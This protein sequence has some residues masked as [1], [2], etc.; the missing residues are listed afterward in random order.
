MTEDEKARVNPAYALAQ[1][2]KALS[3]KS[4]QSSKKMEEWMQVLMGLLSGNL[5]IGSRTPI[6]DMPPWV[7][8][9]VIHGGFASG[10][11]AASGNWKPHEIE[12]LQ[13][14]RSSAGLSKDDLDLVLKAK[15]RSSLNMFY[16]SDNGSAELREMLE[17]GCYRIRIAEEGALLIANWL[18]RENQNEQAEK[19]IEL[20][21]PFFSKLR[22]YPEPHQLALRR[23]SAGVYLHTVADV[24]RSLRAKRPQ[25]AV[26]CMK[27]S[28][29]IWAPLYDKCV[30]LFLETIDGEPPRFKKD[31]QGSLIKGENMQPL[32]SGGWP[33]KHFR[34]GWK[35]R[36]RELLHEYENAR[37]EHNLSNKP[38][39]PK[40]NFARLREAL[41]KV[42]EHELENESKSP[43]SPKSLSSRE[44][45][46]LRR[47]LA[48]YD[49]KYGD[50]DGERLN[51][52]RKG[53]RALAGQALH[54]ELAYRLADRLEMLPPDEGVPDL[55]E[56][57]APL[58]GN[59]ALPASIIKKAR[60]CWEVPL[61][62]LVNANIIQS[63]EM[64]ASVLPL[65]SAR[66][67]FAAVE[68]S[69]LARVC[70]SVYRAF[71]QRRSLLLLNLE[72]QV[73]F[74]ELPWIRAVEPWTASFKNSSIPAFQALKRTSCLALGSF[75]QTIT[76][77]RLVKELRA[78]AKSAAL[79]IPLVDELAADIFMGAFSLNFLHAAWD[80][81]RFL[82]GSL[83]E[84]YYGINYQE[85][86]AIKQP[87]KEKTSTEF[88]S[89]CRARAAI[90]TKNSW[91]VAANG[92]VIE[93]AQI[94]TTHNLASLFSALDLKAEL[95]SDLLQ[96]AETCFKYICWRQQ[97]KLTG[98]AQ[99]KALKISAYA[100]RQMIF[101]LSLVEESKQ[102]Q[103][104]DFCNLF[105]SEQT[106]EFRQR[107]EPVLKGLEL[108]FAGGEFE[109][110]G[111]H[112]SGARRFLGWTIGKHWFFANRTQSG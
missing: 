108:V 96:M 81:G 69:D 76:P 83:Y 25:R 30:R 100:W 105:I 9:E 24:V 97:L 84:R 32:L 5:D 99:L 98:R 68:D 58:D 46:M 78:L 71:R 77:N 110:S 112:A 75:P 95:E 44:L 11:L 49:H 1:F 51:S 16:L 72:S 61:A 80:A 45:G 7:T 70:E 41:R 93:Q 54:H 91:S 37:A 40:E 23:S 85:L 57:L 42:L 74:E 36:A 73:K 38:E 6:R 111:V 55:N 26:L 3:G 29:E 79:K 109:S 19:L 101:F 15:D 65:L 60:R 82:Q 2:L 64:L 88:Y 56:Y 90:D 18:E 94:L 50:P 8:L 27:E 10:G 104:I 107:F 92:T 59:L 17:S 14:L 20:L 39:K 86:V 22:F 62:E 89:I 52:L 106:G 102:S 67:K 34:D 87:E 66:I 21:L 35:D 47:I 103:F 4:P 31:S 63:G 43:T 28:I 33:L 53:Q 12:K 13:A 48:A